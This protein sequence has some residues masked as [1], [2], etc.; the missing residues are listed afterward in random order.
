MLSFLKA[1]AFRT[2]FVNALRTSQIDEDKP[3]FKVLNLIRCVAIQLV[4][5][6]IYI[7]VEDGVRSARCLVHLLIGHLSMNQTRVN[8]IHRL[9]EGLHGH[10]DQAT[11]EHLTV[12]LSYA[13]ILRL[14][15][16]QV[17]DLF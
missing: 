11:H 2:S 12:F 17:R 10:L 6:L 8:N 5:G 13:H 14:R 3:T 7:D 1:D 15:I 9:I 16:E 4:S